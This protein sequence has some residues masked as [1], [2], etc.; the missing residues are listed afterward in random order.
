M[1]VDLVT[2]QCC[3]GADHPMPFRSGCYDPVE[4]LGGQTRVVSPFDG[5]IYGYSRRIC[6]PTS[7]QLDCGLSDDINYKD[8]Q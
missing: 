3:G 7:S 4:A 8:Q 5:D 1:A 2:L 6:R